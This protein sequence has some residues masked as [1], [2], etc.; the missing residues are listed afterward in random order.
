MIIGV[1]IIIIAGLPAYEG[2]RR[3]NKAVMK[4]EGI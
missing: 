4:G 2:L 1:C 3:K